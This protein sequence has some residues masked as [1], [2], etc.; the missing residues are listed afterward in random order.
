MGV[1]SLSGDPGTALGARQP[2]GVR[3]RVF[4][5]VAVTVRSR[6]RAGPFTTETGLWLHAWLHKQL[7][8]VNLTPGSDRA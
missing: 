5:S 3:R 4:R 7:R 2:V 1:D 8:A 6:S